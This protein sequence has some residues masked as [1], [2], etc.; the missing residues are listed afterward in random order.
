MKRKDEKEAIISDVLYVPSMSSNLTNLGQ[1]LDE[2]YTM[3][4]EN[5]E[6]KVL[7]AYTRLILKSR[8]STNKTFKIMINMLNH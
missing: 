2:N 7:D 8:L 1:L 5:K 3:K 6:L 4:L